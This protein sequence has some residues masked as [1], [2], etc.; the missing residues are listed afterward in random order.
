MRL[1][2]GMT[3]AGGKRI[4]KRMAIF[5]LW[6]FPSG[7]AFHLLASPTTPERMVLSALVETL[8]GVLSMI[9]AFL[10]VPVEPPSKGK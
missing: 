3:R 1:L 7:L 5:S 2:L 6:F 10:I 9:L 4:Q 8:I